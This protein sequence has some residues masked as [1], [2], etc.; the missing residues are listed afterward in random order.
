MKG[1]YLTGAQGKPS[2]GKSCG[3]GGGKKS[4][5]QRNPSEKRVAI[6]ARLEKMF[7]CAEK[8]NVIRLK[9]QGIR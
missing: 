5:V 6:G 8:K 9:N 4:G 1:R 3:G 7:K 2:A